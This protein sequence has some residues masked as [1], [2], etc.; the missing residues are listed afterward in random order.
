MG[1]KLRKEKRKKRDYWEIKLSLYKRLIKESIQSPFFVRFSSKDYVKKVTSV[2]SAMTH[3]SKEKQ[4]NETFMLI[5]ETKRQKIWTNGMKKSLTKLLRKSMV[6]KS[7]MRQ[8]SYVNISLKQSRIVSTVGFG[9][10]QLK[11]ED[12]NAN[13]DTLCRLAMC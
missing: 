3:Q 9:T 8:I 2:N 5:T 13:I 1:R 11:V 10:V 7:L 12:K 4:L 6:L